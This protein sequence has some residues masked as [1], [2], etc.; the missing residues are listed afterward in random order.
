MKM[1]ISKPPLRKFS[2]GCLLST[3][4]WPELKSTTW[5]LRLNNE[6]RALS[7]NWAKVLSVD[8]S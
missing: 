5:L 4:A 6:N 7:A 8:V 2:F 1:L 3:P